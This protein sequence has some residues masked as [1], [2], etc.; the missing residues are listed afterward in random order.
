MWGLKFKGCIIG[1]RVAKKG[2]RS[3]IGQIGEHRNVGVE[4]TG[5]ETLE[6]GVQ[7]AGVSE[8]LPTEVVYI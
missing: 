3:C 6:F 1:F 2:C 4:Y 8:F 7:R 5:L